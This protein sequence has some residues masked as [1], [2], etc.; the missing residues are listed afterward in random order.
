MFR[1]RVVQIITLWSIC[2]FSLSSVSCHF[3]E[4]LLL[5]N[6]DLCLSFAF[7]D[8]FGSSTFVG[9]RSLVVSCRVRLPCVHSLEVDW[10]SGVVHHDK[11]VFLWPSG[12]TE[13]VAVVLVCRR[14]VGI[15]TLAGHRMVKRVWQVT[16]H[17][18]AYED[19]RSTKEKERKP[20]NRNLYSS[21]KRKRAE[22][23]TEFLNLPESPCVCECEHPS[24]HFMGSLDMRQYP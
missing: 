15:P 6:F 18:T 16:N 8:A 3:C 14:F 7:N 4:N 22:T 19:Q 12:A 17:G 5:S 13:E 1:P 23:S 10:W 20:D 21:K 9:F 24:Q 2:M 11:C